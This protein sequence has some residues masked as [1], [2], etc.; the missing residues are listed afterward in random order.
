M[1]PARPVGPKVLEAAAKWE[2]LAKVVNVREVAAL[3]TS[4]N[5]NYRTW[6][7]PVTALGKR[8]A[9]KEKSGCW[10]SPAPG[11]GYPRSARHNGHYVSFPHEEGRKA[12]VWRTAAKPW[13]VWPAAP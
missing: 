5:C 12:P 8:F 10:A 3:G 11:Q 9:A 1:T 13:G 2:V 7:H 6:P 4:D